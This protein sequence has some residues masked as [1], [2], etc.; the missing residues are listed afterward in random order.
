MKIWMPQ[1]SR[2][3]PSSLS[4]RW[5]R[6]PGY[7]ALTARGEPPSTEVGPQ[8]DGPVAEAAVAEGGDPIRTVV[9]TVQFLKH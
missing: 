3:Q 5:L 6:Q 7:T 8:E 1:L 2:Q 9:L 4:V